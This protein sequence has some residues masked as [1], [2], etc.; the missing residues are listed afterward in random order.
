VRFTLPGGV[1]PDFAARQQ[2]GISVDPWELIGP[3]G[4]RYKLAGVEFDYL[5]LRAAQPR[6]WYPM[7]N[8][9]HRCTVR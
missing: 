7:S 6:L 5:S 2:F 9:L 3:D 4:K 1:V 8:R